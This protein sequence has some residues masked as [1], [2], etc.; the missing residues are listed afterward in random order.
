M[1][2]PKL[3]AGLS[4]WNLGVGAAALVI[5]IGAAL[6]ASAQIASYPATILS[7]NPVAYYELQEQ[8][9]SSIAVDS[10]P[11]VFD[12]SY[13]YDP[14]SA[15]P[16][17]GFPGIASNSIAFLGNVQGNYGSIDIPYSP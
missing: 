14:T 7:N 5:S 11:N 12:A 6:S 10:S 1:K 9:G 13:D 3:I 17:L 8:P 2:T 16:A 15:S 4:L